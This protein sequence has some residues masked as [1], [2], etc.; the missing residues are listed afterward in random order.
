MTNGNN[1]V[2]KDLPI[3]ER[4][5]QLMN[6]ET[7]STLWN[8]QHLANN[9]SSIKNKTSPLAEIGFKNQYK[10]IRN[11]MQT[12]N[13]QKISATTQIKKFWNV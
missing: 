5:F 7:G 8:S 10:N 4:I 2:E 3:H 6:I 11:W 13:E 9:N 12:T 1:S